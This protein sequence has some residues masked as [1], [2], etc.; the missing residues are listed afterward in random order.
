MTTKTFT[1]MTACGEPLL[2][3][4]VPEPKFGYTCSGCIG[5]LCLSNSDRPA[6]TSG[7]VL[8]GLSQ[9]E[10]AS[11]IS[12]RVIFV[13]AD[14]ATADKLVLLKIKQRMSR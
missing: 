3:K 5:D 10:H 14:Q 2:L 7:E 1:F 8:T 9:N 11:C 6:C 4:S 13:T 12:D